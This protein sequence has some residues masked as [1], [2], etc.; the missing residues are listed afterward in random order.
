MPWAA[1]ALLGLVGYVTGLYLVRRCIWRGGDFP[2]CRACG[3][4]LRGLSRGATDEARPC[5]ECGA[6]LKIDAIQRASRRFARRHTR[7]VSA[8][9]VVV[10]SFVLG[11]CIAFGL[12]PLLF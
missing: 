8:I 10:S 9:L 12:A 4:N 7:Y 1:T 3:Y 6:P 11:T 5:P 2:V